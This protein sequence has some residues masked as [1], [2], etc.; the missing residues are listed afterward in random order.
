MNYPEFR[1]R[2]RPNQKPC[3]VCG[4]P[5]PETWPDGS[6]RPR[7]KCCSPKCDGKRRQ[8]P[9][10]PRVCPQCNQSFT[11]RPMGLRNV[12]FC[13]QVCQ[14]AFEA[15]RRWVTHACGFCQKP[16]VKDAGQA[17]RALKKSGHVFC[18]RKCTA[19]FFVG[20]N[21]VAWRGG[22]DPNRG[23]GWAK[24][25][26]QVRERDKYRCRRCEKTQEDNG[27]KLSVDHIRAWREF[28]D[29]TQANDLSNLVSL[30]R[31]C[32]SWKTNTLERKWLRGDGLA[33]QEY[34]RW[35]QETL[36]TE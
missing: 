10:R 33:L 35:I 6:W 3:V 29:A 21:S 36:T 2:K 32:H 4:G 30:C 28:D 1:K 13:T 19:Q 18:D 11:P 15:A 7:K 24:I 22:S 26:E 14:R 34:R 16:V 27:Q 5:N 17:R 12:K 25:A 20:E 8:K 31:S 9:R 23:K